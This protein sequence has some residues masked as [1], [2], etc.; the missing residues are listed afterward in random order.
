MEKTKAGID[1]VLF[2]G[3]EIFLSCYLNPRPVIGCMQKSF[4]GL[5]NLFTL[6]K[7]ANSPAESQDEHSG[8][9]NAKSS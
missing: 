9:S 1:K 3:K 4:E 7:K 5:F 2:L 8:G 6:I